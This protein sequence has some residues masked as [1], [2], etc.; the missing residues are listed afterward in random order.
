MDNYKSWSNLRKQ[1]GSSLCN[2]LQNRIT[3]FLTRYHKVHNAYGRASICLD[4]EE[5]VNFSWIEMY[6]QESAM[7]ELYDELSGEG[8]SYEE[9]CQILKP[10]WDENG[11]Y[12]EMDFL[13]AALR[14]RN[15]DICEALSSDNLIICI[16][17]ILDKRVG[18]RRLVKIKQGRK[19]EAYPEWVKQFYRLRLS[20][21]LKEA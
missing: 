2:E 16:L 10:A 21:S 18:K 15:M 14:F 11:T 4:D 6:R 9:T 3:Y 17:A 7:A 13:D 20:V 1:L 5:L 12:H 8:I 19:Y